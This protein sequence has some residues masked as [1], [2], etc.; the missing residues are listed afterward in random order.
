MRLFTS[1]VLGASFFGSWAGCAGDKDPT[2]PTVPT[3]DDDDDDLVIRDDEGSLVAISW[4]RS[5]FQTV[6][7]IH[8]LGAFVESRR[9]VLNLAQCLASH[10]PFCVEELPEQ[11][12][13]WVDAPTQSPD[14]IPQL[15]SREVGSPIALGPWQAEYNFDS[16]TGIGS[17]FGN[18]DG[19]ALP[20]GGLGIALD[21]VWGPYNSTADIEAP[22]LITVTNPDPMVQ[23][24]FVSTAPLALRWEPGEQG[25]IYL[26][27]ST[28][29]GQQ[30][31]LLE[32]TGEYDLDLTPLG[33]TDGD[34]VNLLLGRWTRTTVDHD[35]HEIE[36]QIQSN[37]PLHGVWRDVGVRAEFQDL[38][39]DCAAAEAGDSAMP[40]N[41]YGTLQTLTE[42]LNPG[43]TGCTGAG[44]AGIDGVIPID[45]LP[46]DLLTVRYQLTQD[47]ASLYLLTDCTDT[48]T[49]LDGSDETSDQDVETVT[50]LNEGGPTRVYAIL[51]SVG[52]V[53]AGYNLDI[54]IDSL[55][56]DIL[57][58]TCVD[59]I[60]QGPVGT[61]VYHGNI[62]GHADLLDPA[63]AEP[64]SGG[65]GMAQIYL[66]P[67]QTLTATVE[68]PGADPK[69]Y[70]VYNC[71]LADSCFLAATTATTDTESLQYVNST[72]V[73]EYFYLVVDG[74][75]NLGD[76]IL[77]IAVQ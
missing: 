35:G 69:I 49:C 40:G 28:P 30:L 19:A 37:Q 46:Q 50:W 48:G 25:D 51:D 29:V 22:T 54:F 75:L 55:G 58:P 4:Q 7:E 42:D 14:L 59:A 5:R 2:I 12:G 32:D 31:Y 17:Y 66:E 57:V 70:L 47:D 60:A 68:A 73:S 21:G 62:G 9:G 34:L 23:E 77:D 74:E 53:T 56:G 64:A 41:Y 27:V 63:C 72:G 61:G 38:Y 3:G 43:P 65:E 15:T 18:E 24:D 36:V 8:L 1:L 26:L 16:E 52:P 13:T 10:V 44:A 20:E 76:Y 71:S 6:E 33:L 45:L 39:D 11:P 67:Q